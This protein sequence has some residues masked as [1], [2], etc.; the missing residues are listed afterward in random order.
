MFKVAPPSTSIQAS[1]FC[2]VRHDSTILTLKLSRIF[3]YKIK[4]IQNK[5]KKLNNN[6]IL[7]KRL[8]VFSDLLGRRHNQ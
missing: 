8:L 3:T 5:K 2:T 4:S 1:I 7:D 6:D